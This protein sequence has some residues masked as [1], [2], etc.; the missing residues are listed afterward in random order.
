M[1]V[2]EVNPSLEGTEA[3]LAAWDAKA[4]AGDTW[5]AREVLG[6]VEELRR[7]RYR[8]GPPRITRDPGKCGGYP[9]VSGTR[10]GVHHVV[11]LAPRYDWD[12]ERLRQTEFPDLSPAEIQLAVEYY[13]EHEGEIEEALRRDSEALAEIRLAAA[14]E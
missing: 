10:I 3:D 9:T 8:V 11:A 13:K 6:L 5:S 4:R 7:L 14:K 1:D 12:L 2:K